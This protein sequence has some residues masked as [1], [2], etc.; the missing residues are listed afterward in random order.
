MLPDICIVPLLL[1]CLFSWSP[2]N[3]RRLE[4]EKKSRRA[5]KVNQTGPVIRYHSL[6]MP[7]IEEI[8]DDE[9]Q[10]VNLNYYLR[11]I[12]LIFHNYYLW[13][14]NFIFHNYYLWDI[15]LIFHNF[16]LWDINFIFHNYYLWDINLIFHNFY[17]WDIYL[18]F[19]NY[20]LWDINFIFHR[21]SLVSPEKASYRGYFEWQLPL[22]A[23]LDHCYL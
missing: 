11:D 21:V 7:L 18:I 4:L 2:E 3:Y 6:T 9:E 22:F 16:Y 15:N 12:N 5:I 17:L 20:Y 1:Y 19:H 14:I 10:W 23:C 13:D 8:P